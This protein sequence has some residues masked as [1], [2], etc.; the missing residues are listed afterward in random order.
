MAG[1]KLLCNQCIEAQLGQICGWHAIRR[2]RCIGIG[3]VVNDQNA[4]RFHHE[5]VDAAGDG[6]RRLAAR[7]LREDRDLAARVGT[8][9]MSEFRAGSG[10][11]GLSPRCG[12][13]ASAGPAAAPAAPGL[14]RR[15][16]ATGSMRAQMLQQCMERDALLARRFGIARIARAA[17]QWFRA[18]GPGRHRRPRAR[19]ARCGGACRREVQGARAGRWTMQSSSPAPAGR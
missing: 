2:R 17:R 16:S 7:T 11:S 9:Q 18:H 8:E 12:P 5:P 14:Q 6:D 4:V 13:W 3:F 10:S 15:P 19:G 1:E